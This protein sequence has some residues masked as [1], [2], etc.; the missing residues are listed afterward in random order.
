[1]AQ[2]VQAGQTSLQR[3]S[4]VDSQLVHVAS[5]ARDQGP[6]AGK[7]SC[8]VQ[9]RSLGFCSDGNGS[10]LAAFRPAGLELEV[11]AFISIAGLELH[12]LLTSQAKGPLQ[13]Q[14][15]SDVLIFDLAQLLLVYI[16]GF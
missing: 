2:P 10:R 16:F 3:I 1:M 5:I 11:I 6:K 7:L 8:L 12:G 9:D 4:L 13:L 14:A 15:H